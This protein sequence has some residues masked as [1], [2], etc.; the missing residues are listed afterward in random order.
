[1]TKELFFLDVFPAGI[2]SSVFRLLIKKD[3]ATIN[4]MIKALQ[5]AG[6]EVDGND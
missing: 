1:M 2:H 3:N 5:D 4:E 6:F